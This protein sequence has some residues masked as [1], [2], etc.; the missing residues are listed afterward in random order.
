MNKVKEYMLKK[1]PT[2]RYFDC[3]IPKEY[4]EDIQQ[5]SDQQT[6]ELKAKV[7]EQAN[8]LEAEEQAKEIVSLKKQLSNEEDKNDE[9]FA[10]NLNLKKQLEEERN[11]YRREIQRYIDREIE[12]AALRDRL[13][14]ALNHTN[15]ELYDISLTTNMSPLIEI[16]ERN[17]EAITEYNEING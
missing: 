16:I 11:E 6:S 15:N 7:E 13:A 8:Q 1:Y 9:F 17:K 14:E 10:E 12:K 5:F 3:P 4:W 2:D